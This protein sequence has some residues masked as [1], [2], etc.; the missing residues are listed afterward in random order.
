MLDIAALEKEKQM[1]LQEEFDHQENH[2]HSIL[3]LNIQRSQKLS[4]MKILKKD[5]DRI[6]RSVGADNGNEL[7]TV[8]EPDMLGYVRGNVG[9]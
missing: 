9:F 4:D 7:I 1:M 8:G 6:L 2:D 3:D 5:L